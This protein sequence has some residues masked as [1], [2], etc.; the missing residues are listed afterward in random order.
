MAGAKKRA[1][2]LAQVYGLLEPGP[3]VLVTTAR[4]GRANIMTLSWHTMMEFEPPIV[5]CVISSQNHT[6]EMLRATGECVINVPTV[7]LAKKV[8]SC[9]NTS[10]Q[11]VDK[12]KTFGLTPVAASVVEA[13]LIA[14]CYA[15]LEC[16]VIDRKLVTQYNFFILEV[17]KAWIDSRRKRPRTIHH[18]G[19]GVFMVAGRTIQLPSPKTSLARK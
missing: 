14:E 7:E 6:F 18:Q 11:S 8:V 9:G 1:F 10:G 15:N 13:P 5:G 2:P 3:I 17:V 12:F 4:T 19:E 16:K